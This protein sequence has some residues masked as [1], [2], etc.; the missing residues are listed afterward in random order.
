MDDGER[1][2]KINVEKE[3]HK[4][5]NIQKEYM[6]RIHHQNLTRV[7]KWNQI[8][9]RNRF[10][11]ATLSVFVVSIYSYT[12]WAIKQESF[13]DDFNEPEKLKAQQ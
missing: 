3:S 12:M 11:G 10:L 6:Q 7:Q 13:L 5:T 1:M 8:R 2:P 9:R 4:L